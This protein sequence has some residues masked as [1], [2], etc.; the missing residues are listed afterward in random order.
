MIDETPFIDSPRHG[1]GAKREWAAADVS[2]AD[3]GPDEGPVAVPE[4]HHAAA[5]GPGQHSAR[6][7]R[8]PSGMVDPSSRVG[9]VNPALTRSD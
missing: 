3:S 1:S 8:V 5:L 7:G 4:R 6:P 9:A 2:P